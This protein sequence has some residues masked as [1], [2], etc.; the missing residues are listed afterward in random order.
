M[1]VMV[2]DSFFHQF[3]VLPTKEKEIKRDILQ[4]HVQEAGN[5]TTDNDD[6]DDAVDAV[7]A[8]KIAVWEQD[9]DQLKREGLNKTDEELDFYLFIS[10]LRLRY[11]KNQIAPPE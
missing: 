2:M 10:L 9:M 5:D 8:E 6:D 11:R 1:M 3:R 4:K 7:D